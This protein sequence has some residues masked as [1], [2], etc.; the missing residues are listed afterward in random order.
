MAKKISIDLDPQGPLTFEREV[1][2]PTPDGKPLKV[3]FTFKHRTREE[4]AAMQDAYMAKAREQYRQLQETAIAEKQA[5][6]DAEAAGQVYMPT[7]A[8]SADGVEAAIRSD[9][10]TVMDCATDWNLTAEFNADNLAK[11]FRRYVKAAETI[12]A[13]YRVSMTQGRLG[14]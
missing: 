7:M 14:N 4:M 10:E 2:I 11:F 13:D 3:T 8:S 9:V 6:A 5:Q 12:A 1:S